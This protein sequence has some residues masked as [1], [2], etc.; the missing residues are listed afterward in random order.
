MPKLTYQQVKDIRQ[1]YR[2]IKT[3]VRKLATKYGVSKSLIHKI[4]Q[5]QVYKPEKYEVDDG[6]EA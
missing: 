3:P 4:L 6:H 1:E 5:Y 2:D